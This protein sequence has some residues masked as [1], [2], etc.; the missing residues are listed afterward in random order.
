[1]RLLLDTNVLIAA[2]ISH[3]TCAE[4]LEHCVRCHEVVSSEPLLDEFQKVLLNKFEFS[5]GE[6]GQ[7]ATFLK[8]RLFLA[9]PLSLKNPVCRD[10]DDDT[11]LGT[12][13]AGQCQ[14]LVTGDRDLLV[15]EKF[16]GVDII[17]PHG[18]WKYEGVS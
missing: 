12:A 15:L 1:M 17:P 10:P 13:I 16:Q 3:G 5:R 14:C 18:F 4:L 8:S 7:V 2:F 9:T 6:A 11:V